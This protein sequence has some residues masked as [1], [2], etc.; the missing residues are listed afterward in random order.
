VSCEHDG[1]TRL[2][3][4]PIHAR[5]WCFEAGSLRIFD[6]IN[7]PHTTAEAR[8]HLHPDVLCKQ[9]DVGTIALMLPG[10]EK[11]II[12]FSAHQ[13]ELEKSSYHPEFGIS[14]PSICVS[15]PFTGELTSS[16]AWT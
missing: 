9:M 15:V 7:G 14:L 11:C 5:Q 10:G 4:K 1:Y 8:F 3:G 16:L 2:P 6:T 12:T 13:I